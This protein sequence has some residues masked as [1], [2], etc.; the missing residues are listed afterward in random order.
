M[1]ETFRDSCRLPVYCSQRA[2]APL[3]DV[4]LL[5]RR[6]RARSVREERRISSGIVDKFE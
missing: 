4:P 2:H 6:Y 3:A 1:P 5:G